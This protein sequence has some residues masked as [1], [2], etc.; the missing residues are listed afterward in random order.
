MVDPRFKF[1]WL[2]WIGGDC[3]VLDAWHS[4]CDELGTYTSGPTQL[5]DFL[6]VRCVRTIYLTGGGFEVP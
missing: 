5:P 3:H 2:R 6:K 1:L 4:V